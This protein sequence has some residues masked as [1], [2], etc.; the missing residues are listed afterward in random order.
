MV[1]QP[2]LHGLPA[3]SAHALDRGILAQVQFRQQ[4]ELTPQFTGLSRFSI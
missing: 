2:R 4:R 3:P 1:A